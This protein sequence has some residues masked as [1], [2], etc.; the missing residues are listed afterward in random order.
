MV[1]NV[2]TEADLYTDDIRVFPYGFYG[3]KSKELDV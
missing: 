1:K 3:G 2:D